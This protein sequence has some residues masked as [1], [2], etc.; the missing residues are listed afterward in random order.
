MN[1]FLKIGILFLVATSLGFN[2]RSEAGVIANGTLSVDDGTLLRDPS[3]STAWSTATLDWSV[4][5]IEV[6][7][8]DHGGFAGNY[9]YS[10]TFNTG[11]EQGDPDLSHFSLETSASFTEE[12]ILFTD[13]G[14][15]DESPFFESLGTDPT[16]P[17]GIDGTDDDHLFGLKWDTEGL[18]EFTAVLISD[19]DPVCGD[20]F[21]KDGRLDAYNSGYFLEDPNDP[22]TGTNIVDFDW[23]A[24]P[25]TTVVGT[26]DV[27]PEP[28]S[29]AIFGF[30]AIGLGI[31]GVRRRRK[32]N[33]T[34]A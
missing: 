9:R 19:R 24:T 13:P 12:N 20:V 34:A 1:K 7:D 30:G 16:S 2:S 6:G 5:L 10:Y 15:G 22:V 23:L 3:S 4:E 33:L 26:P 27:I 28:T 31:M 18:Q 21:L 25:D 8:A 32:P 11:S 14:P 29:L 17:E